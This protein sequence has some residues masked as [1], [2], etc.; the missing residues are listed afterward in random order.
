MR[1]T[2]PMQGSTSA[3]SG[4]SISDPM[5]DMYKQLYAYVSVFTDSSCVTPCTA[6]IGT[7]TFTA[8]PDSGVTYY[9]VTNGAI[10]LS[11]LA[12]TGA[13]AIDGCVNNIKATFTGV[14]AA[15]YFKIKIV[16]Y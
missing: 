15:P 14:S 3:N 4:I 6:P 2:F 16:R 13:I 12:Q 1:H 10:D 11:K 9:S 8:S 5:P 7:V